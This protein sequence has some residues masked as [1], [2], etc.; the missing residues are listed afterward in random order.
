VNVDILNGD[1]SKILSHLPENSIDSV[2]TDPPYGLS[3]EPNAAEVLSHWLA[4]DDYESTGGGF[5]GKT[6]DSFVPGPSVWREVF[7]VLKPGG[8][9]LTFGG[10]RTYD[11]LC[12]SLRL[13]GFEVRDSLHWVYGSGFPKSLDVSKAID[14]AAGAER[15]VVGSRPGGLRPGHQNGSGGNFANNAGGGLPEIVD[16]APATDAARQWSGWGT[17]LKPA[18]EPIVVA[19]KPLVGTVAGNVLAHGT[20]ALNIDGTRVGSDDPPREGNAQPSACTNVAYGNGWQKSGTTPAA[21]RWPANLVFTHAADCVCVES[22]GTETIVEM[23]EVS[24]MRGGNY[25]QDKQAYADRPKLEREVTTYKDK[26]AVWQCAAGCPV[27]ELD[28]QS[29]T[30]KGTA[31][32]GPPGGK[33]FGG[34]EMRAEVGT[35][36]GDTGGASRFF[37]VTEWDPIADVA[38]FRYVAKPSKRE[39]NAGLD[40]L[41][42]KQGGSYEG[43]ADGSLGQQTAPAANTHPTVKPVALM[44]WLV[45]LVTPPGGVVLDPFAGSGTTLVAAVL[46]GVDSIG[47]EMTDDYL[48][49]IEGRVAWAKQQSS[50]QPEA[51]TV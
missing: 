24:D 26:P 27:A 37:T 23:G 31:R 13:A 44:R 14:K 6:W 29:G 11:L 1:C 50:V 28:G 38:P 8:H 7:R 39:R 51:Q 2:V 45:R 3:K 49:I 5:M 40:G 25:G 22:G 20:G 30:T 47:I 19:R 12:I 32:V 33:T 34:S 46:E 48:P 16:T 4:G 36:F 17:A 43:R 41:P 35:W 42:K 9:L 21:G 15:E 10:T 18:H